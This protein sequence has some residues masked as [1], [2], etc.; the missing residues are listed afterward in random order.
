MVYA[1]KDPNRLMR[2]DQTY[3][4][5]DLELTGLD[6]ATD[7]I[8]EVAAVKFRSG[9]VIGTWSSLVNPRRPL[10]HKITRLTGIKQSDLQRAPSLAEVAGPLIG[11]VRDFPLVGHSVARDVECLA[12]EGV[13]LSNPVVDTFE[14]TNVLLPHLSG[15][16]L[17]A[18][19]SELGL[20]NEQH[21]RAAADAHVSKEL[22]CYLIDRAMELDL[23]V[24]QEINRV[25][26]TADWPLR[27]V[28]QA[29]EHEQSRTA[30]TG[31]S[32]LRQLLAAKQS[33]EEASLDTVLVLDA[34]A[35]PLE[36]VRPK[37]PVDVDALAAVLGPD[38][39]FA[40]TLP[41][42]ENR[43]QQVEMLKAVAA[44]FNKGGNLLVEAGTGTGKSLAYLLP[45]ARFAVENNE[46]V[47]I[48]TKTINLQ[49]QLFGKDIPDLQRVLPF[50]FKAAL[51]KG[52]S[53]YLCL[54]RYGTER[55]RQGLSADE[56]GALIKILAWLP[57]TKTGDWS[58]MSLT[59][60]EKSVW[61]RLAAEG[62]HC[63]GPKCAFYRKRT[64]FLYRARWE[65]AAAHVIVVN[66]ALLLSQVGAEAGAVLPEYR[67]LVVDE[68]HNLEDVATD[69]LSHT[70]GSRE[71]EA[72]LDDV[73]REAISGGRTGLLG[74]VRAALRGGVSVPAVARQEIEVAVERA[75][76]RVDTARQAARRF[77]EALGEFLGRG[78]PDSGEYSRRLRLTRAVRAQSGW[79]QVE[80]VW[81]GL[82]MRLADL[83]GDLQQL[84]TNL[85]VALEDGLPDGER[86]VQDLDAAT[87]RSAALRQEGQSIVA[88][89]DSNYV[90]WAEDAGFTRRGQGSLRAAP[91]SVAELLKANL[92]EDKEAVVLTSATLSIAGSCDYVASRVGLDGAPGMI[93]DSPFDYK[94]STLIYIPSDIPEPSTPGHQKAIERALIDLCTATEGRALVLFTSH[95]QL[96]TTYHA[97]RRPLQQEEILVLAQRVEGASRRQSA[98]HLPQQPAN[99]AVG[100]RLVLGGRRRRGRGPERT[101]YRQT[102]VRGAD[103]SGGRRP[104]RNVRRPLPRIQPAADS[105]AL[106]AGLWSPH[107]QPKRPRRRGHPRPASHDQILWAGL[108][109][110]SPRLYAA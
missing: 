4:A 40:R 72:L 92:F 88:G 98:S 75:H 46:H 21:H 104:E 101:R 64:C 79:V 57:T 52:R 59:P 89:P 102:A 96:A 32:S 11:F 35:E 60:G 71:V 61:P 110:V 93:L 47:V 103:G 56:A 25:A 107:S 34:P 9:E 45:A 66:H 83:E 39:E 13:R 38:G 7:A 86:L 90:Q 63:L 31:G 68:A 81:E 105:V 41:G 95:S 12:R 19:A 27:D 49:D 30:F 15:R 51:L 97:I 20:G 16:G 62:E 82:S 94:S 106:Q 36:P 100:Q 5:L 99:G 91:L 87:S 48:S 73:S 84:A 54:R 109:T 28:F 24:V 14:L 70:V 53:N 42:Y 22:F 65:A 80:D 50:P 23:G 44:A 1:G 10:P 37:R 85:T 17:E 67:Y 108:L 18:I 69:Q 74:D 78:S 77:G 43:P 6:Q 76:G 33:L 2:I 3:V 29:V 8:I 58:E 55:R 26:A